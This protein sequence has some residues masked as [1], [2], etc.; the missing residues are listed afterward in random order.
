[1]YFI[2][3][4]GNFS[5]TTFAHETGSVSLSIASPPSNDNFPNAIALNTPL[6]ITTTGSSKG[7]TKEPGEPNHANEQGGASVWWKWT[8]P[9]TGPITIT[10]A[11]TNFDTVLGVYTGNQV[12]GLVTIASNDDFGHT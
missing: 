8:S 10:T 6:P 2:A 7:A 12:L 1:N 11:G 9:V 4:D 3:V 5:F